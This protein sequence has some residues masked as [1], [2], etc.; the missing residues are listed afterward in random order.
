MAMNIVLVGA[1]NLAT[2]IGK[3][4]SRSGHPIV[5]VYSRTEASAKTLADT[6]GCTYT[7]SIDD[8]VEDADLY[9]IALKDS[10]LK[11]V[12]GLLVKGRESRLFV[13]TAGSI[14]MDIMPALRRGVFY[15]MQ[16]FS[17]QR[18]VDFREIPIFIEAAHADDRDLLKSLASD[19]SGKVYELNSENRKYLH[20]AAVFCC[21]FA[22][23]CFRLGEKLLDEHGG[24]PFEVMLP[25]IDET[26]R[27]LHELTPQEAQTGPAVRW[28]EN[29]IGKQMQLLSDTPDLQHIYELLSKSIHHDKL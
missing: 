3:A 23:H 20:L 24:M 18:E 8:I 5:Q 9:I 10:V 4:I 14:D 11:D 17:K 13:H 25:L 7:I 21:N 6:L 26:A 1:G 2:N 29:V 19:I 12:A 16:T 22:N 27:K 28:D 15:P